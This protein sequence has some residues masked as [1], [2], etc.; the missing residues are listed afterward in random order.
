[1]AVEEFRRDDVESG[2]MRRCEDDRRGMACPGGFEP[3]EGAEAPAI[4][5]DEPRKA[6]LRLRGDQIIADRHREREEVGRHY[7]ADGMRSRIGIDRPATAVAKEARQRGMRA[8]DQRTAE[9]VAVGRALGGG[10]GT[11]EGDHR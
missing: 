11:V 6:P 4:P 7:R 9:D 2:L 1:M 10:G 3:A 8:G 5:N